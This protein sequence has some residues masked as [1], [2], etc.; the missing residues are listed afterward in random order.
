VIIPLTPKPIIVVLSAVSLLALSCSPRD[1]LTRRLAAD[2]IAT[3][4]T[5]RVR[6]Q[7]QFRIGNLSNK[8][9]IAP[10]YLALQHHGWIS[11]TQSHCPPDITPPP[12]WDVA[13][14]PSG[15]EAF[16]NL[17]S[18]GDAEKQ[19]FTIPAAQRQLVAV[20][21]IAKH[22]PAADVEFTWHW[23]P[24]NEVGAAISTGDL[25]FSSTVSFR[26]YDDGWRVIEDSFHSGRPL[27]EAL[28]NA[29]PAE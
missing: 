7:F 22:G 25:R 1:F 2:L 20:T 21:G 29:E 15:V 26:R 16:Q 17:I 18:P 27:D 23:V 12:C 5:F 9:Y 24:L 10:D 11:S 13:L 19:S 28:K 4:N 14:T 8:D 3:S 6:Q